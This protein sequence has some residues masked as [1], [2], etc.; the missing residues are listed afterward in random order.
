[1]SL[2]F[3]LKDGPQPERSYC[4][5]APPCPRHP[6]G[7]EARLDFRAAGWSGKCQQHRRCTA[8]WRNSILCDVLLTEIFCEQSLPQV[9]RQVTQASS[10]KA[11]ARLGPVAASGGAVAKPQGVSARLASRIEGSVDT[12]QKPQKTEA[13]G[14]V[15]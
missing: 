7:D 13:V 2:E 10:Q 15:S 9:L 8:V 4:Y 14:K 12:E 11:I 6:H 3:A 1:M 5:P